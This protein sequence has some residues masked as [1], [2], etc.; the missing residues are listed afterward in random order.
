M[1]SVAF[2][3]AYG[4]WVRNQLGFVLC[5]AGLLAMA[6]FY[7]LLFAYSTAPATLVA[8]TVPLVFIFTYV[9][10]STIFAQETGSLAS[11]Y[12]R[13][14]L[15][16]PVKARSLVL[17]PMLFGS[18]IAVSLLVVTVKIVYR[19]SGLQIPLGLPTLA[20]VVIVS[21]FQAIAWIPLKA[22]QVRALIAMVL[23]LGLGSLPLWI[24]IRVEPNAQNLVVAILVAYLVAAY[25][26]AFAA[27]LSER[28]GDSWQLWFSNEEAGRGVDSAESMR[29]VRS[30]RSAATAQFWYEWRCHGTGSLVFLGFEMF[31]IW[32]ILLSVGKPIDAARLPLILSLLI[33]SPVAVIGST[34]QLIGRPRP[35]WVT[36][37][38][39][40]TFLHVRPIASAEVVAGKLRLAIVLIVSS[41]VFVI[42]GTCACLVLTRSL[43]GVAVVWHRFTSAYPGV[44]APAICVLAGVFVPAL[45]FRMMTDG[46]PFAFTGR[47]WLADTA[48]CSYTVL[49]VCAISVAVWLA[50][51]PTY[52]A[53]LIEIG[54]WLVAF[55]AILKAGAAAAVFRWAIRRKL[56]GWP[57]FWR[58]LAIWL[59]FTAAVIALVML[60]AP[61]GTVIS[62][63][64]LIVSAATFVPLVRFPLSAIA[65]D[66]NRHR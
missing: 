3:F 35:L 28:R 45:M 63:P 54:P 11:S 62:K 1:N 47:K 20:V 26:L 24:V 15:V 38:P 65:M 58:I 44:R 43:P 13:H 19:S 53:R 37:R 56:M 6:F 17:W 5:G 31:M 12:P 41:W 40:N 51:R 46:F 21:W 4:I 33:L 55:F 9:L 64:S 29:S 25:A 2:A 30:Y 23:T 50:Q 14:M 18:L 34:G 61:P 39:F 57:A 32:G 52:I 60:L 27:V 8:S 16:L 42:F 59:A 48:V 66:W 36:S 10:N 49:L 7:P 22:R